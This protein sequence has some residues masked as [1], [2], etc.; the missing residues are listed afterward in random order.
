MAVFWIL[1]AAMAAIATA[2]VLVPL[3]RTRPPAAPTET[4][5]NLEVLRGQRREID[6]DVAAGLLPPE[7]RERALEDLVG[8][9]A[10]DL[11]PE[12]PP[13]VTGHKRPWRTAAAAA[14][15]VPVVALAT[16]LA[17]GSPG[18][19][20]V[21][22]IAA[23]MDDRQ[24]VAMVESLAAKMRERPDDARGWALL[25][26][27]MASLGRFDEA[28]DA[29]ARLAKL[30]PGNP[31]ILADY[32]D[33]LAMTQGRRLTGRPRELAAEALRLDPQH[34]KALALAASAAGEAGDHAEALAHWEALAAILPADSDD[35][36]QVRQ[37]IAEV[38]AQ[39]GAAAP[40]A[41][42]PKASPAATSASAVSGSVT[43]APD[44]AKRLSGDETVF[45]LARAEGGPRMPLAVYRASARELPMRFAL[46]DSQAMAPGMN[47]SSA[48]AVRVEARISRS[49]DATPRSGDF[50]GASGVVK[51]GTRDIAI[52]VDKVVP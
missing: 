5:A 18:S 17:V 48:S 9:A 2:F 31:D 25:G 23:R 22:A 13:P 24:I 20:E 30:V 38:R 40:R 35:G 51:P 49:G 33:A 52:V 36:R 26:R 14:V 46:D 45:V 34:P 19:I 44:I 50:V 43:L 28:A 8:R 3:L 42:P 32:A 21:A 29:Y 10:R 4:E 12:V 39:A 6:A 15:A 7:E 41:T 16:Y 37:V 47:L 27:S 11:A 1:A